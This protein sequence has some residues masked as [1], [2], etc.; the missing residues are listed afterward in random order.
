MTDNYSLH[1]HYH[2]E[3]GSS[4]PLMCTVDDDNADGEGG[5]PGRVGERRV[6]IANAVA[7]GGDAKTSN[8]REGEECCHCGRFFLNLAK[9]LR[10][11]TSLGKQCSV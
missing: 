10:Q 3:E 8:S 1:Y 6:T 4:L 5:G 2:F 11:S 7:G 9:H